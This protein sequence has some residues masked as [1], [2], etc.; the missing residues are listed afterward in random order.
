MPFKNIFGSDYKV[1]YM[2]LGSGHSHILLHSCN[3]ADSIYSAG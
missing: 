3:L 2:Y 1:F